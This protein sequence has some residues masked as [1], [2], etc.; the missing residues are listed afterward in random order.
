MTATVHIDT[1]LGPVVVDVGVEPSAAAGASAGAAAGGAHGAVI[2]GH[3]GADD[4]A[5]ASELSGGARALAWPDVGGLAVD[6]LVTRPLLYVHPSS[7][8]DFPETLWC[9]VELRLRALTDTGGV[10]VA[11]RIADDAVPGERSSGE[12][13][14]AV[15][16][17]TPEWELAIGGPDEEALL[18]QA[19]AD[20]QPAS[21]TAEPPR[22]SGWGAWATASTTP[23]RRISRGLTWDLPALRATESTRLHVAVAWC[24]AGHPGSGDAPWFAVDVTSADIRAAAGL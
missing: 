13:L 12:N 2:A 17:S 7:R 8:A 9:A 18:A 22:G 5:S 19:E 16:I 10:H 3:R 24:R 6:V 21:W 20:G 4:P 23:G 11:A 15:Q 1:P 14:V